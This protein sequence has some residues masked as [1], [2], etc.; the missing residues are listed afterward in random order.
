MHWHKNNIQFRTK[1]LVEPGFLIILV[2]RIRGSY[3]R[4]FIAAAFGRFN[5]INLSASNIFYISSDIFLCI[6]S[7]LYV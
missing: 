3:Y 4:T 1:F 7:Y 2:Q 5:V 6:A